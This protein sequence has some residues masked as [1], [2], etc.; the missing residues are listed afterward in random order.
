MTFV[1]QAGNPAGHPC[2]AGRE[3]NK[4]H[5]QMKCCLFAR[6]SQYLSN[7]KS[8]TIRIIALIAAGCCSR[9]RNAADV[10]GMRMAN[11]TNMNYFSFV[12]LRMSIFAASYNKLDRG[13]TKSSVQARRMSTL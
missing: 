9:A 6:T 2:E 13:L 11:G 10:T 12:L 1:Y 3:S 7:P 8:D 4:F 5:F